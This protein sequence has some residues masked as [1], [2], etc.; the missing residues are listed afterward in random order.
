MNSPA[1]APAYTRTFERQMIAAYDGVVRM[2]T[3]ER[4]ARGIITKDE[5]RRQLSELNLLDP[6]DEL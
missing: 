2:L 5:A 4:V 1:A 3:L 6:G